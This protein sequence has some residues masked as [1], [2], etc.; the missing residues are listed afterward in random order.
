MPT[1]PE[2]NSDYRALRRAFIA[3][4]EA[5]N[6]DA[7]ARVHP[8]RGPDGKPLFQDTAALGPRDAAKALLVIAEGP[9]GSAAVTRLLQD[10]VKPPP[11]ARLVLLHA[12][13]P[14][15]FA[16]GRPGAAEWTGGSLGAMATEDLSKVTRLT[17]LA[18][19]GP[20]DPEPLRAALPAANIML[21]VAGADIAVALAAL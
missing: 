19:D 15:A 7:I 17:V 11:G 6:V 2:C 1:Q 18:L 5:R 3:A 4:C 13:D 9:A 8:K 14:H 12:L 20:L 10:G 21:R 16:W